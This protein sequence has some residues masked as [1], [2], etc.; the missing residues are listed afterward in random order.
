MRPTLLLP[1]LAGLTLAACAESAIAPG[2]TPTAAPSPSPA[3]S[4]T[5][6]FLEP[7]QV[8]ALTLAD[9]FPPRDLAALR[10]DPARLRTLIATGDVLPAR[11]TDVVIRSRGDDFLY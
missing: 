6:T 5:P 11:H 4:P 8:P 7:E 10:L 9:V 3:P 2:H 1:L